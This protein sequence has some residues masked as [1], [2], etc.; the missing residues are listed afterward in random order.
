MGSARRKNAIFWLKMFQKVRKNAFFGLFFQNF[1]CGAEN[2]TKIGTKQRFG[3]ARKINWV[4]LKKSSTKFSKIFRKSHTP[5]SPRE[6]PRSAPVPSV[7]KNHFENFDFSS[8]FERL[9]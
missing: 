8:H 2:L 5:P 1:A 6:N 7:E 3:R 4:D 9:N